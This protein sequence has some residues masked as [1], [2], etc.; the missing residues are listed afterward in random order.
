MLQILFKVVFFLICLILTNHATLSQNKPEWQGIR[1]LY[2]NRSDVEKV[3]GNPSG[4]CNCI[5]QTLN[6]VVKVN[7]ATDYCKGD[8]YGWNV[9]KDTVLYFSVEPN[10][11][12]KLE[13]LSKASDFIHINSN[14]KMSEISPSLGIVYTINHYEHIDFSTYFPTPKDSSMRCKGF[15]PFNLVSSYYE[16]YGKYDIQNWQTI[17]NGVVSLVLKAKEQ[18]DH[19]GYIIVYD[20]NSSYMYY[21]Y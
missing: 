9:P 12:Q 11:P 7:Y 1:P 8:I 13:R 16:P 21:C 19:I 4:D 20:S 6:E 15:P 14:G 10:N 3:L 18:P 17:E 5:Y 2:S